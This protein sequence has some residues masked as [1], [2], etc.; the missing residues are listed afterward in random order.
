M[1]PVVVFTVACIA[2]L[3][4]V[5]TLAVIRSVTNPLKRQQ[6]D[7]ALAYIASSELDDI[8]TALNQST[9]K[10]KTWNQYW[11]EKV[12]KSGRVVVDPDGPGKAMVIT[13]AFGLMFGILVVGLPFGLLVPVGLLLVAKSIL[14]SEARKRIATMEKQLPLLLTGMRAN[15][16]AGSTV[17]QAVSS[18]A[19]DVPQPLGD[20]IRLLKQD[21][22]LAVPLEQAI[23]SLADRVP[24]REMQFLAASMEIAVRCGTDLEPQLAIIQDVVAQRTR[25]RQKLRAAVG[26]VKPTAFLAYAAV[27]L[28][29]LN[30]NR[31]PENRVYWFHGGTGMIMLIVVGV[32][33]AAGMFVI[34]MMVKSVE[35]S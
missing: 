1:E 35:N 19:D 30:S 24:S 11:A 9:S 26:Q 17:V 29:F 5:L 25:I 13:G 34:R 4:V 22:L 8:D 16:Q 27:P 14:Q 12:R 10:K 2:A 31:I 20:E 3:A 21:L 6:F 18:V 33:Y 7:E 28:M 23:K 15:L 32:L